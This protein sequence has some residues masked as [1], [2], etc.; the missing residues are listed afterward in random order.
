[1]DAMKYWSFPS[2]Y[3]TNRRKTEAKAMATS[4]EYI[5]ARKMDGSW[6]MIIKDNDGNFYAR[7]RTE[8]VNGGYANKAE[9]I[10]HIIAELSDIPNGTVLVG[11][12]YF[13]NN[14]GSRKVTS[15]FNC[16]KEKC[17][18]RQQKNGFLHFYI[19]DVLA[20]KGKSLLS[21]PINDRINRYLEYELL[22][23]LR[24][25]YLDIANYKEGQELWDMYGE[26]IANGGE[27][28][29][30]TKK[31]APYAPGKRTARMTLK[32]KKE[33]TD[34]IDAFLDGNYKPPTMQYSGKE[35]ETWTYWFNEKTGDRYNKN[36]YDSYLA[37]EPIIPVTKPF[38]YNWASAI[39][40]SVMKDGKPVHIAWISGITDELKEGIVT[41]PDKWRG[42][43]ASLTAMEVEKIDGQYSLRHG[44]I[45]TWRSDK[46]PEDCE[47]SQI[48]NS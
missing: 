2:S 24:G 1:M 33:L 37:G 39:S 15:V 38:F 45:D 29:V 3:D 34:T 14:E 31:T 7:S 22:D 28:I 36:M 35:I 5:G 32:M 4:G 18:E 26:I 30:I 13:P 17:I 25:D 48:S 43:V 6:E 12:I 41:T 11:E 40:F 21:T 46:K 27:G 42:K 19:F 47:W 44:K 20:Y 10:P 23:V 9:W 16:L 8:S